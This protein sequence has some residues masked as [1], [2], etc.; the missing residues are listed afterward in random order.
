MKTVLFNLCI[1]PIELVVEFFFVFFYESFESI[2]IAVVGISGAITLLSLPLY[3]K[4]E[5]LQRR[6]RD[7]RSGMEKGIK[8]I[9][10]TFKGDEQYM[11]LSAFYRQHNY[12]P[13]YSLRSSLG[14]LIQVPFFIAAY[15]FLSHLPQLNGVRFLG[16]PDLGRPDGMIVIG[17]LSLNALPIIMTAI[18][19]V[20]AMIYTKGFPL[21]D[22]LQLYGMALLFLILLYGSPAGLVLY[23]TVN[24]ILSLIKNLFYRMRHPL[25]VFYIVVA[26]GSVVLATNILILH[27]WAPLIKRLLVIAAAALICLSPLLLRMFDALYTKY[28]TGLFATKRSQTKMIIASSVLLW[29]IQGIMIPVLLI[30][31][32]PLEFSFLGVVDNPLSFVLDAATKFAGL[33]LIWLMLIYTISSDKVRSLFSLL[34]PPLAIGALINVLAFPGNYGYISTDLLMEN[35]GLLNPSSLVALLSTLA[36]GVVFLT[37]TWLLIRRRGKITRGVLFVLV[38][39]AVT[40]SAIGIVHISKEYTLLLRNMYQQAEL[41]HLRGEKK[42]Y[43]LSKTGKNVFYVFVDRAI[44]SY[45]NLFFQEM[46]ELRNTFDGFVY[47]PN[48]IS[49]GNNTANGSPAQMAGYEYTPENLNARSDERMVDKHNEAL[50]VMPKLFADAGYSVIFTD[51]PYSNYRFVGDYR[52]FDPYPEIE[53]KRLEGKYTMRYKSEHEEDLHWVPE[54]I[55]NL[56]K[57]RIP[58]FS[59]LRSALPIARE[60]IYDEGRFLLMRQTSQFTDDFLDHY[61]QLYYLHEITDYGIE[62]NTFTFLY[63]NTP[64]LPVLLEPPLYEPKDVLSEIYNPLADSI[65]NATLFDIKTYHANAAMLLQLGKW[66]DNLKEEGVYDNTRIIIAADHGY[67]VT[68]DIFQDFSIDGTRLASFNPLLMYKDFDQRGV[69]EYDDTF[70][71]NADSIF[72]ALDNLGIPLFNPFTKE[73]MRKWIKKDSVNV[74]KGGGA[75]IGGNQIQVE[76]EHSFSIKDDIRLEENWIPLK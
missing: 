2:G 74:Y 63:N 14:L 67:P 25:K 62:G 64:H 31:S 21:K 13:L 61:S 46:P 37:C 33:Y 68:T 6:E 20:S 18:N 22:R 69:L 29:V 12:H 56:L 19:I 76:L 8:R 54:D 15:H 24:N 38:M 51:P 30:Q 5:M 1:Y 39:G 34:L 58:V 49:F 75:N 11:I 9:K 53:V 65:P 70:M 48:T 41:S 23:W 27:P 52:P 4:A 36:F 32:S 17:S 47:Y 59:L 42:E 66:L 40:T 7:V 43:V 72:L 28:L 35:P 73:D 44:N 26:T 71:T 57:A 10:E 55:S 60:A 45:T 16:I 3:H 50:L